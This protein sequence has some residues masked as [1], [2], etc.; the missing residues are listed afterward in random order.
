MIYIDI[1]IGKDYLKIWLTFVVLFC[2][3]G[4]I[5][6]NL[7]YDRILKQVPIRIYMFDH[8]TRILRYFCNLDKN[9]Q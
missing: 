7:R 3:P 9:L 1:F 6:V 2:P 4:A 5:I 8:K